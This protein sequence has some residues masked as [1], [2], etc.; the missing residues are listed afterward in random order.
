VALAE[1]QTWQLNPRDNRKELMEVIMLRRLL[2]DAEVD[3]VAEA[4]RLAFLVRGVS[5]VLVD[6]HMPPI[7]G[8]SQ[9]CLGGGRHHLGA[10]TG[11]LCLRPWPLGLG[12]ARLLPSYPSFALH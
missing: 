5:K 1:A 3:H 7:P 4:R 2:H 9:R 6:L 10:P 11:G 8:A 12:S